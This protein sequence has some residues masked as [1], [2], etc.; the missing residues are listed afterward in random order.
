MKKLLSKLVLTIVVILAEGLA[1]MGPPVLIRAQSSGSAQNLNTPASAAAQE[2][3]RRAGELAKGDR[4]KEAVAALKQAVSIAPHYLRA[5]LEY[6]RIKIYH[7]DQ[8]DEVRAEYN[9]LLAKEPDDPVYLTA[10]ALAEPLSPRE[11]RLARFKKVSDTAPEWAWAH[12][13]KARMIENKEPAAAI[14]E[15]LECLDKDR[16]AIEAYQLLLELQEKRLGRIEDAI[17]TA[18][19]MIANPL[20]RISGMGALWRLRLAKAQGS[21]DPKAKLRSELAQFTASSSDVDILSAVREAYSS[22]LAD[23]ESVRRVEKRIREVDSSWYL[24][25]GDITSQFALTSNGFDRQIVTINR[26]SAIVYE[27]LTTGGGLGPSERMASWERLLSLD[28]KP[29]VRYLLY[30]RLF[31]MAEKADDAPAMVKYGE[32]LR[33]LDPT[34]PIWPARIALALADRRKDLRKALNYARVAEKGTAKFQVPSTPVNTNPDWI[35]SRHSKEWLQENYNWTRSLALDALGWVYYQMGKYREAVVNL[36]QAVALHRSEKTLSRLS[37]ALARLGRKEE[38]EKIALDA[39]NEYAAA[40][41]RQF[42]NGPAKEFELTTIDGR[43]VK[44]SD[45]KGKVIMLNFWATWCGPCVREAPHIV[46]LYQ[47]YKD[48]GLEILA[49]SVD[50]ESDRYKV[51][52]FAKEHGY[53]FPVL[54]AEGLEKLYDVPGY[55]TNIF[56]DRQG[57]IR[58]REAGYYEEVPRMFEVV[59]SELLKM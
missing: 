19:K 12:Y 20:T 32:A 31:S 39:K 4:P 26:Q 28:P 56:I 16:D 27:A 15:L 59:V 33:A 10:L 45:F 2:L 11:I 34:G 5:H 30:T 50:I 1:I 58:Y 48:Q 49:L 42:T 54:F 6:I 14:T 43:K 53:T 47:K 25:R 52:P 40:I 7:L 22:L 24:H 35:T 23:D 41:K 36:R 44:L 29:N 55:P 21:E 37:R 13:A 46:K 3:V 9:S 38:A 18:E 57:K 8:Y 17:S 51:A